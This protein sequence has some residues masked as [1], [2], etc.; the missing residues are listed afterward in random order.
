MT[1]SDMKSGK[2][3]NA[4]WVLGFLLV[5]LIAGFAAVVIAFGRSEDGRQTASLSKP[6]SGD[7][8]YA[9]S[10][11][12]RECHPKFHELW[13]TSFHGLAL[14]PYT[15]ELA[16]KLTPQTHPIVAGKYTFQADIK[17]GVVVE[18][19]PGGTAEYRIVQATGG[20]N[21]FYFL[22]QME[23][24]WL[25]TLPTAYDVRRQEWFDT[26]ASAVRHFGGGETD[27]ALYWKDRPLT[28]NTSCHGCHVSQLEKNYDLA[29]DSYRTTWAEAGINCETCHG[30]GEEHVK[31]FQ[32]WPTNKP[33]PTDIKLIVTRKLS[34]EQ[35]NDMCAPC[36]AKMSPITASFSPGDRYFDHFDLVTLENADFYPD[37]RDLGENY[38]FTLW[39]MNPCAESGKLDCVHCHT[40]SGR[41]RFHEPAKANDAC[42]PCHK[43]KVENAPAHTHHPEGTV[44]NHCVSCHMPMTE[45]A[46]MRR[47][48]HSVRPPAPSATI[49]FGSPNA[50]NICHTNETPQWAD[51]HV[52]E[53]RQRDYQK[54]IIEVGELIDAARKGR[55]SRLPEILAYV[56]ARDRGEVPAASL[57][58]LLANC[59]EE[60]KWAVVRRVTLRD[61]SPLVRAAAADLLGARLDAAA[62]ETLAA[63][64][65]DDF[66]LVRVRAASALASAS[67]DQIPAKAR[68]QVRAATAEYISSMQAVPDDMAAH[69][70]FGN[71]HMSRGDMEKALAEFQIAMRLQPEALP[72]Y[73]NAALVYNALG[74]NDKA[75][76][77]LRKALSL[78]P[79]NAS[80]NLNLGMLLAEMQKLPEAEKALRA[81]YKSDTNMAQAAYNLGLLVS[82]ERPKEA[83]EW[84]A[85]AAALRP[86][87]ARYAYAL[88]LFQHR[89]GKSAEAT[90]TLEKLMTG[91]CDH[92]ESYVLLGQLYE[93]AGEASKAASVYRKAAGNGQ[94]PEEA[95][96]ALRQR[97]EIVE[98]KQ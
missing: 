95:R 72:P 43:D 54:P 15:P 87:E 98:K 29:S 32:N 93:R 26:T 75:E 84:A 63:A 57:V 89:Q 17:R 97:A 45:F 96:A 3:R 59:P 66:R 61:P 81:A 40:S 65:A 16:K 24:G 73:A 82:S 35:R 18:R 6:L 36:H 9:G 46:R 20:K 60:S 74:Q 14:Q 25:Q 12:C 41:Y 37:G 11:S 7:P 92:L 69:Y 79:T 1:R 55:W 67:E 85:R 56:E 88:A 62:I 21:V 19:G 31:L 28:F 4:A 22:T 49:R 86:G 58:R 38:T 68:E 42:M 94:I 39:R 76:A 2:P 52:R 8:A 53:W 5:L 71:Y 80:V 91:P 34:T 33:P 51:K 13:S 77:S 44:G 83:L 27:Q 78:E 64:A 90:A 30:P 48:D 70:N 50:C 47:S 10:A 23:R